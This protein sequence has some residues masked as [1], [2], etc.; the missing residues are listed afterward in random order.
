MQETVT[1]SGGSF[2]ISGLVPASYALRVQAAHFA[3]QHL[4]VVYETAGTQ[5]LRIKME[6]AGINSEVT[7]TASRGNVE[8]PITASQVVTLQDRNFLVQ[9][10]L[11][12]VGNALDSS[13]GVMVQE[14]THGQSSPFMRG[15]TGYQTLLLIDGVRFNTSIFRSGPNQ[16]LAYINPSQLER[17]EAI[18]GPTSATYGSDSLGGTINLLTQEAA[19]EPVQGGSRIH[20]ELNA[21]GA[22]GDASG[23]YDARVSFG[24]KR[25]TWMFGGT[26][27]RLNNLRA[28][29]GEDS[30]TL[31]SATWDCR[32]LM[33]EPL[34]RQAA[35]H[36]VR[37]VWGGHEDE[38][39]H[40]PRSELDGAVPL[41]AESRANIPIVMNSAVPASCC[42]NIFR[43]WWISDTFDTRSSDSASWIL[44]VHCIDEFAERR[45]DQAK[46]QIH[47]LDHDGQQPC[48]FQGIF[49]AGCVPRGLAA[50]P[51]LWRGSL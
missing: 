12:T 27:R 19:F 36:G 13:P 47:R 3:T 46:P 1:D 38:L 2:V 11:T 29:E 50:R 9:K 23:M 44:T 16:Y 14:T 20:G 41:T 31:S 10:P 24:G 17:V 7:V 37:T 34:G 26:A 22:S 21:I 4:P 33:C 39:A 45:V 28:G 49:G 48:R 8:T 42:R 40:E 5:T 25:L 43:K 15:L 18:L 30:P 6:L 51:G 35:E 32:W